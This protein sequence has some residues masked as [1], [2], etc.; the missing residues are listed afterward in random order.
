MVASAPPEP[1]KTHVVYRRRK[2]DDSLHIP[3]GILQWIGIGASVVLSGLAIWKINELINRPIMPPN[4]H[5]HQEEVPQDNGQ[6]EI[7]D[8][9]PQSFQTSNP[10]RATV[11]FIPPSAQEQSNMDFRYQTAYDTPPKA[12]MDGNNSIPF[13]QQ[14]EEQYTGPPAAGEVPQNFTTDGY[15]PA[16][17]QVMDDIKRDLKKNGVNGRIMATWMRS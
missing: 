12:R 11:S 1:V 7:V 5:A 6:T 15:V 3:E 16:T 9:P 10:N 2:T 4:G 13:R 14:Q 8:I 17:G